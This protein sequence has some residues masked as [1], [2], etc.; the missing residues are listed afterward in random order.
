[1]TRYRLSSPCGRH[2]CPPWNTGFS[3]VQKASHLEAW[4]P[5]SRFQRIAIWVG[6][7]LGTC[8]FN[9]HLTMSAGDDGYFLWRF[10]PKII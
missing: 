7:P 1:L 5:V 9:Y 8:C 2:W 4:K 6:P 10:F 3:G